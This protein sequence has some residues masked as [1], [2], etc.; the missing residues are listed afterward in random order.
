MQRK[1]LSVECAILRVAGAVGRIQVQRKFYYGPP[2]VNCFSV[3]SLFMIFV[4]VSISVSVSVLLR[5][6]RIHKYC[7]QL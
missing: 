1:S 6:L 2:P 4:C 3:Y 7:P 5:R